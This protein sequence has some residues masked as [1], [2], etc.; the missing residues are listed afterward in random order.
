MHV[1]A[2]RTAASLRAL[3]MLLLMLGVNMVIE[4]DIHVSLVGQFAAIFIFVRDSDLA[5]HL[6]YFHKST[7]PSCA[8]LI[9][10]QKVALR[11]VACM[12]IR[13]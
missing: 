8:I 9:L 5:N 7:M 4:P 11:Y 2:S 12:Q 10:S 13:N 1:M 3:T 6:K